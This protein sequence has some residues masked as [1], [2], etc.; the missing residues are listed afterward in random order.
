MKY[1]AVVFDVDG[2]LI[3]SFPRYASIMKTI[4]PK[5]GIKNISNRQLQATFPLTASQTID[6]LGI[7]KQ[8]SNQMAIDY[9]IA[10]AQLDSA[11]VLYQGF[12]AFFETI[13]LN[14]PNVALGI[15][16]SGS[17]DDIQTL[18]Q[19]FS[20]MQQMWVTVTSDLLPYHKPAPEPL[21]YAIDQM[22]VKRNQTL[23]IGDSF[24]DEGC[25]KNA[26]VDFGLAGWGKIDA[27]LKNGYAKYDFK[28]PEA[29]LNY[30]S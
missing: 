9:T 8:F 14:Y 10:A 3:D 30:L 23:Y 21:L 19:H 22:G 13:Q 18:K 24:T 1:E 12:K 11:P 7:P 29:I 2:T 26:K 27:E 25:A 17:N 6:Y 4:T 16:T 15:V 5:Y 28:T 20:F